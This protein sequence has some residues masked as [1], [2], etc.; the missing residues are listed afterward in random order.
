MKAGKLVNFFVGFTYDSDRKQ[1]VTIL[2]Q[3]KTDADWLQL[4]NYFGKRSDGNNLIW[5]ARDLRW[6]ITYELSNTQRAEVNSDWAKKGMT[7]QLHVGVG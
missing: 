4:L 7:K 2:K 3:M 5:D 1:A 6:W